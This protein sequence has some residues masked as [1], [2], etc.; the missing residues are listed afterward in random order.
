MTAIELLQWLQANPECLAIIAA[1]LRKHKK[2][3]VKMTLK[4]VLSFLQDLLDLYEY[5]ENAPA[6][7]A[8]TENLS[9]V[10]GISDTKP[11]SEQTSG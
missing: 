1:L 6:P 2:G 7:A 11:E 4:Q 8:P 5:H 9:L 10:P 3:K